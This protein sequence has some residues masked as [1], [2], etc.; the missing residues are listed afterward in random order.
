MVAESLDGTALE[1]KHALYSEIE[2]AVLALKI[3]Q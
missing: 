2:M 1:P 3:D